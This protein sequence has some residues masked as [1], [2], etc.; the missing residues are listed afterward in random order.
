MLDH[1]NLVIV[2][3]WIDH[4]TK[5]DHIKDPDP[6]LML[7]ISSPRIETIMLRSPCQADLASEG[8]ENNPGYDI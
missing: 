2:G 8:L 6:S 4:G 7:F 5:D 3:D 1:F